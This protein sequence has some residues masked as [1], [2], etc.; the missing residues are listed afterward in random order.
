MTPSKKR[1]IMRLYEISTL[2][3]VIKIQ[4]KV[5]KVPNK[6]YHKAVEIG[7]SDLPSRLKN[8]NMKAADK[9]AASPYKTP[10]LSQPVVFGSINIIAPKNPIS[11]AKR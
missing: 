3:S 2:V 1:I 4:K 5:N 10:K 8:T 11:T 6:L 9:G 7:T